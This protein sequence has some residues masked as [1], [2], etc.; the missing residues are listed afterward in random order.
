MVSMKKILKEVD[1]ILK[2]VRLE[3]EVKVENSVDLLNEL[4]KRTEGKQIIFEAESPQGGKEK[5]MVSPR[6]VYILDKDK[7]VYNRMI[8]LTEGSKKEEAI[9]I[10]A[11]GTGRIANILQ[12]A[13]A[14][15]VEIKII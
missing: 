5:L 9:K 10:F 14:G 8:D 7:C 1:R 13:L 11:V 2:K 6:G 15:E 12:K 4:V 3:G